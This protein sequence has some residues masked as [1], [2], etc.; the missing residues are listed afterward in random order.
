MLKRDFEL[1]E[2]R[3]GDF[4]DNEEV[5]GQDEV[6]FSYQRRTYTAISKLLFITK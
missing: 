2:D 3:V 1:I 4:F 6:V 5:S